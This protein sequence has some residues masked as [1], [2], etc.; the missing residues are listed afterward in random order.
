MNLYQQTSLLCKGRN[1]NCVA[2]IPY[3]LE[4]KA[5][6]GLC[7]GK[8]KC[9]EPLSLEEKMPAISMNTYFYS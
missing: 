5:E 8:A 4:E 6:K 1:E 2:C 7:Q 3:I 9:L